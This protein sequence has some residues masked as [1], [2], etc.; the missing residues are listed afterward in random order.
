[1]SEAAVKRV[2][3]VIVAV[4][5]IWVIAADVLLGDLTATVPRMVLG[6]GGALLAGSVVGFALLM[7]LPR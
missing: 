7:R 1:M 6:F 4:I 3:V 5:V 2:G